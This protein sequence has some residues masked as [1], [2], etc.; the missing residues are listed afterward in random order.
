MLAS[1][2]RQ[3][4]SFCS[5]TQ[6][7]MRPA[8]SLSAW[9]K[10]P[11]DFE[12]QFDRTR[13][14]GAKNWSCHTRLFGIQGGRVASLTQLRSPRS[15]ASGRFWTSTKTSQSGQMSMAAKQSDA[16]WCI[17]YQQICSADCQ[18]LP[19]RLQCCCGESSGHSPRMHTH[20]AAA[21]LA[22]H[23]ER[24]PLAGAGPPAA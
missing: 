23:P 6:H 17:G 24:V 16:I 19:A 4:W 11:I 15:E 22:P 18:T 10:Q 5:Q 8:L 1:Y 21:A 14:K 2:T 7:R 20:P 13:A 12:A 3:L 9:R